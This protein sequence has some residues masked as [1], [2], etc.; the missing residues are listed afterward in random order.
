M[1]FLVLALIVVVA[2]VAAVWARFLWRWRQAGRLERDRSV[3][4]RTFE[5][6]GG[7]RRDAQKYDQVKAVAGSKRARKQTPS[8]RPLRCLQRRRETTRRRELS[9]GPAVVPMASRRRAGGAS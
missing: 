9:G 2:V 3:W 6:K 8:G 1:S 4:D 5:A 7:I